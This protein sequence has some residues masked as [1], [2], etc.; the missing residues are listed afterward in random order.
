MS[1][2]IGIYVRWILVYI[3]YAC[4]ISAKV[5]HQPI[6]SIIVPKYTAFQW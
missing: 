4:H 6:Y 5:M 3:F 2:Y 1:L